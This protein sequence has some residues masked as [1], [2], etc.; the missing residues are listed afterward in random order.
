[1]II[2]KFVVLCILDGW[3]ISDSKEGN[4]FFLVD[5]FIIDV[6]MVI[7]LFVILIIYGFD[8]GLFSGQMG[9]FEVGYINI[10]VGCVVVMDFG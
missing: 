2:L 5:M 10:G 7:S 3:G 4:V 8:V 6:M 1:M 9:N